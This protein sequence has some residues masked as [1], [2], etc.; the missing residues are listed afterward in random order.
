MGWSGRRMM[1]FPSRSHGQEFI[2]AGPGHRGT[3][4]STSSPSPQPCR[5]YSRTR[6]ASPSLRSF[7]LLSSSSSLIAGQ[8]AHMAV[9]SDIRTSLRPV[10]VTKIGCIIVSV[11][12][13]KLRCSSPRS[14]THANLCNCVRSVQNQTR[15]GT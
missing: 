15:S 8:S 5:Q 14:P 9:D 12:S 4:L 7:R 13:V 1:S 6:L 2:K 3:W 11:L 10:Q